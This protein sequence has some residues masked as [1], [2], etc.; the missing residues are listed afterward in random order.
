MAIYHRALDDCG[1]KNYD[2]I[3]QKYRA[4][5]D[6]D[7][8]KPKFVENLKLWSLLKDN[9]NQLYLMVIWMIVDTRNV[10]I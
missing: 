3:A 9:P 2:E 8:A 7:I 1:Y 10:M 6:H 4:K 5:Q